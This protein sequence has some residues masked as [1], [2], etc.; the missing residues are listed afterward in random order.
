MGLAPTLT[1]KHIQK[2]NAGRLELRLVS[3]RGRWQFFVNNRKE[4]KWVVR[5]V[6]S[7]AAPGDDPSFYFKHIPT[8]VIRPPKKWQMQ[9]VAP[10][11]NLFVFHIFENRQKKI[12][13]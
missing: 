1:H 4:M 2:L 5:F 3:R 7:S 11:H 8:C 9:S 10:A 6:M 13:I 12:K